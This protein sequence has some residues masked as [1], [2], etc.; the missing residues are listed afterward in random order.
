M[1]SRRTLRQ[2]A[3]FALLVAAV[4][5]LAARA[6]FPDFGGI[7]GFGDRNEAGTAKISA[8]F[9]PAV[10][11]R[12]ALVFVTADVSRGYHIYAVDQGTLPDGSGPRRTHLSLDSSSGAKLLGPFQPLAAP[13]TK[14]DRE[15]FIGLELR[16]HEGIVTWFAPVELP[17][18]VDATSLQLAGAI[19]AQI[20]DDVKGLCVP[21]EAEFTA[22]LGKGFD[23]PAGMEIVLGV[24]DGETSP[25]AEIAAGT[26]ESQDAWQTA[27]A[28]PEGLGAGTTAYELDKI[29]LTET[30]DRSV[31]YYLLTALL[32]GI[33]L[34]VMPCVLPVIGLKVMSFVQQ[35]GE[36]RARAWMLNLWYS[37][38]I[39]AVFLA[40]ATFAVTAQVGWGDQFASTWFNVSLLAVV[41]AMAL[42]MLGLWEIP[43]PGFVG[44]G[45]AL[46]MAEKEG[47]AAAFLKG[48]LTTLLAT[49]CTAPLMASAL[50]WAVR[51]PAWVTFSVFGAMGLGMALPYLVVGAFPGLIRFLPKPGMWMETFKKAMG[52]VLLGTVVWFLSFLEPP[53]VVPTVAFMV[54]IAAACWWISQTPNYEPFGKRLIA[55]TQ[56]G[57]FTAV[58]AMA[59]YGLIYQKAML[60]RYEEEIAARVQRSITGERL[61]IVD[62]LGKVA[63]PEDLARIAQELAASAYSADQPWQP[64]DLDRLAVT[65]LGDRRTVLVDFTADWCVNCKYLENAV[66]KSNEVERE[67]ARA[68]VVTMVADYTNKPAWMKQMIRALDGNGVPI[69]A[70]FPADQPYKPIVLRGVYAKDT[71]LGHLRGLQDTRTAARASQG[72]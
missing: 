69:T 70:I 63:G 9:A 23:L 61:A 50:A 11:D 37:A 6:Q 8:Q 68:G 39:L 4:C 56:A 48:I 41:Y 53:L 36:S 29:T 35:A 24:A 3:Q 58:A 59:C 52:L 27:P 45:A 2:F 31:A 51:Q 34:N 28:M 13:K 43:I 47:P 44:S 10:G 67:L 60:P 66:L 14:I 26:E 72:R 33:V 20:C 71:L 40:L 49:P 30:A 57:M 17:A 21:I 22:A 16:E 38:G 62:Q 25:Q 7:G 5:P 55:W 32:G 12:P 15:A 42:S 19:D 18:G 64:F 65:L 1:T 46:D 54:A